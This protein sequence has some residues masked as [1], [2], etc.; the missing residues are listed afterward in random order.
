MNL[1]ERL[2]WDIDI[3][4][5]DFTMNARFI[6]HRVIQRGALT[7]WVS[8]KKFYGLDIILSEILLI[9]DLDIKTLNF[10]SI[11]FGIDKNNFRCFSTQQ[12]T[13]RH[14]NF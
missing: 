14:Y 13:K 7:D 9:R 4:S 12:S 6:I 11:Y 3:D 10:F 2:F 5:L 1:P 8:I